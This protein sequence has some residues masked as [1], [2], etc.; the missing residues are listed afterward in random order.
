MQDVEEVLVDFTRLL[1]QSTHDK[2]L[3]NSRRTKG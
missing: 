1:R 3:L 2:N